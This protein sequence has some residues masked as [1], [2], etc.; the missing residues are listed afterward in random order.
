[1]KKIIRACA[2]LLVTIVLSA[3]Q[4]TPTE[5]FVV[6]KDTERM[7][8]KASSD[9]NGTVAHSLGIPSGRYTYAATDA[10]GR[11]KLEVDAEVLLPDVE[12][13]PVARIT[14]RSFTEQDVE[15]I[16]DAVCQDATP[17]DEDAPMPR[18]VYQHTLDELMELRETGTLDKYN[19]I[20]ELDAAIQEVLSQVASAPEQIT[21]IALNCSFNTSG[22]ARIM[23][24][25]NN[26]VLSDLFVIN[27]TQT[28]CGVNSDFIRD[29]FNRTEFA[30]QSAYGEAVTVSYALTRDAHIVLPQISEQEALEKAEQVIS[31]LGLHDFTCTGT[32][33]APL[34]DAPTAEVKAACKSAYEFMF[35]RSVNGVSV[36]YTNDILSSPPD[37]TNTVSEPWMYEKVRIFIDDDGVYAYMWNGPSSITE[38]LNDKATLLPFDQIKEIFANRILV[39]YGDYIGD[40][41]SKNISINITRI[42]LGLAR[43]TEK[44]N[45]DYGILVPV[46]DFFGTYDQGNGYP[47]G[48]DGYESLLTINAIDG[49]II[50]RQLGY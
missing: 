37:D 41:A 20:E 43:V 16:Y 34:F 48:Y 18:F 9:E 39:K 44:N 45:N 10:S 23:C 35:T 42:S 12:Y 25:Q 40:D 24:V 21:P 1:M 46:W 49:S 29:V 11:V 28:G 22:T 4:P 8:E 2:L 50:D 32:R 17:I 36:T 14:G 13:L 5:V 6:E 38:I 26:S 7:V 19:S 3:C 30:N 47:I 27:S 31:K 33:I 15:N